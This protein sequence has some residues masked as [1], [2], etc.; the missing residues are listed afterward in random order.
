[1]IY[2]TVTSTLSKREIEILQHIADGYDY[3]EIAEKLF[4][5][6]ETVAAH[7]KNI[8]RKMPAKNAA[9]A[10]KIAMNMKLIL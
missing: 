10:V 7:K 8:L 5:S 4:L 1:M 3:K 9:N 6:S 2:N